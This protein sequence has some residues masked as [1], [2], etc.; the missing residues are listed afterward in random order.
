MSNVPTPPASEDISVGEEGEPVEVEELGVQQFVRYAG[1]SG[2]FTPLHY[3][4][5]F[6][7]VAGHDTVIAQGMLLAGYASQFVTDWFGQPQIETFDT[8]F[9]APVEAGKGVTV[10]GEVVNKQIEGGSVTIDI[11]FRVVAD[12]GTEALTGTATARLTVTE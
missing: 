7:Q 5:S 6:A 11:E 8:R 3:E 4:E 9:S 2:D 10:S 12:D 1:A